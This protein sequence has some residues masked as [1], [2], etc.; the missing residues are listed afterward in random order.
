MPASVGPGLTW[1]L[2][3]DQEFDCNRV[4]AEDIPELVLQIWK[5]YEGGSSFGRSILFSIGQTIALLRTCVLSI[6]ES[7][8][9]Q[10]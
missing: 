9:L 3:E 4:S 8:K 6:L 7:Q 10:S 2:L 5:H 1:E